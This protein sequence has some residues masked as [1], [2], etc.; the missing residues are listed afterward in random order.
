MVIDTA[1]TSK[2][3]TCRCAPGLE[4]FDCMKDQIEHGLVTLDWVIEYG[5]C[6]CGCHSSSRPARAERDGA[7]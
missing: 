2:A 5:G 4:A 3:P 6:P 1:K 7:A